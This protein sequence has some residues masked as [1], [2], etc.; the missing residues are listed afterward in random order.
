MFKVVCKDERFVNATALLG[1][2]LDLS[3]NVAD[4]LEEFLSSLYGLKE[5]I[6][7]MK[8][9]TDYLK[10]KKGIELNFLRL[11]RETIYLTYYQ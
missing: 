9:V 3:D 10:K 2:S 8:H 6:S 5:E 11:L 1:E 4:V 7:I